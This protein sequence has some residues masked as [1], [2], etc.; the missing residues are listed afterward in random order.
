[1]SFSILPFTRIDRS[2]GVVIDPVAV[3]LV[4]FETAYEF[5]IIL[6]SKFPLSFFYS[7]PILEDPVT[8]VDA[9][10]NILKFAVPLG[11]LRGHNLF[12]LYYNLNV[13]I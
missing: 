12:K 7:H 3:H 10:I 1:M 2:T 8:F 11:F 4:V 6:E 5:F 9:S 13:K